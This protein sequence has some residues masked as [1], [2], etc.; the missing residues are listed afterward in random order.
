MLLAQAAAQ[1]IGLVLDGRLELTGVLGVGAYGVV[2]SAV[3]QFSLVPYA[4]K[5]LLRQK[6]AIESENTTEDRNADSIETVLQKEI[7]LLSM[8]NSHPNVVSVV[9]IIDQDDGLYVAMEYCSEGDLFTNITDKKL[10]VGNDRAA[11]SVFLQIVDAIQYCHAF[12]IYHRDVKP[13]NVLVTNGGR[14]VKLS[15]F[16]LATT[17]RVSFEFGCGSSFYMS[18]ECH[19]PI[20]PTIGYNTSANDVWS[21]GVVLINLTC[22]RNPWKTASR[23]DA[24]FCEY[25]KSPDYLQRILPVS[26]E[27]NL[28]LNRV[29]DI[30]SRTRIGLSELYTA[31]SKCSRLTVS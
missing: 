11:K 6:G 22:G 23:D 2:Y 31:V 30:N 29:F 17:D 27:L 18:P 13:E 15:D 5:A 14:T 25:L 19:S 4:V 10:Y 21:L 9:D 28:I 20:N 1:R 16:G 3:D 8:A 26:A 12:G 7:K 24:S